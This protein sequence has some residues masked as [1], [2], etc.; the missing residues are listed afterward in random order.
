[1]DLLLLLTVTV[2]L[3]GLPGVTDALALDAFGLD[4]VPSAICAD[5]GEAPGEIPDQAADSRGRAIV[6][7]SGH[8]G[9]PGLVVSEIALFRHYPGL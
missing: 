7:N 5:L 4:S 6:R 8:S 2:K 9:R 1:M 3:T